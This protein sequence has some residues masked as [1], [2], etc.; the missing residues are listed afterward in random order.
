MMR[1]LLGRKSRKAKYN[2]QAF[3]RLKFQEQSYKQTTLR[4]ARKSYRDV[5]HPNCS[6]LIAKYFLILIVIIVIIVVIIIV[7]LILALEE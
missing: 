4:E 2:L 3:W 7:S 6:L 1:R 5:N